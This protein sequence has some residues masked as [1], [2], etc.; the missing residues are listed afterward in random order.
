[1]SRELPRLNHDLAGEGWA[2]TDGPQAV[3]WPPYQSRR[4]LAEAPFF[5]VNCRIRQ[6]ICGS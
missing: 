1:M 4:D 5:L 2:L 3:L 6:E